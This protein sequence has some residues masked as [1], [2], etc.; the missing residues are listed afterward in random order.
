MFVRWL[1]AFVDLPADA[2]DV[3]AQFWC[4]VTG[5]I[6]SP[7]R[8][9]A[10]QF[11]TLL[12]PDGDAYLRV[13][14]LDEGP[15]GCHL[16]VHVDDITVAAQRASDLGATVRTLGE[17][18]VMTSP[19][20]L[21]FCATSHHGER[22]RPAPV[23]IGARTRSIVD[24]LCLDIPPADHRAEGEFWAALTGWELREGV[25]PEFSYLARPAHMPVRLLLQSLDDE[26]SHD[27]RPVL[28]WI[29]P[30]TTP[31]PSQRPTSIEAPDS[32]VG[33]SVGS[34]CVTPQACRTASPGA[35]PTP[36]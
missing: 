12:P 8:G 14:R 1:T 28:T 34:R 3:S 5:S 22:T 31:R 35:I 24:Q 19:A 26:P 17:V 15:A 11:A 9:D 32:S 7:A 25:R 30:A 27:R 21:P 29:S 10:G 33:T 2:F 20:G 23:E 13:Q 18:I 36:A 16:D 6:L 4:R